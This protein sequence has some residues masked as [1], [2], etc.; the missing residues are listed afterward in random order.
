MQ[1]KQLKQR[2]LRIIIFINL[3]YCCYFEIRA[4]T[5][6]KTTNW[7]ICICDYDGFRKQHNSAQTHILIY[8][9]FETKK[10]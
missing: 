9:L 3:D 1:L 7:A 10:R 8:N 5:L 2:A 6:N 4:I